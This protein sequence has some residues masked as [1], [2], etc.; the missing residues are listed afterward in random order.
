LPSE[1]PLFVDLD[2]TV[3]KSDML[4]ESFLWLLKHRPWILLFTP[5]WLLRGRATLKYEIASRARPNIENL[6]LNPEFMEF[7]TQQ[8]GSGREIILISASDERVTRSVADHLGLFTQ[9]FGS[10]AANNLKAEKKLWRIQSLCADTPYAYAGDS[11]ADL[12]VWQNAAQIISVNASSDVRR[13]INALQRL[14]Q[15]ESREEDLHFDEPQPSFAL[16]RSMR[17]HQWLKNALLFLPLLLSHRV[18]ETDLLFAAFIGF[19]AFSLC[20]S[21]VYLL[22]DMLDLESDRLHATKKTRPFAAGE[23]SLRSGFLLAPA[24]LVAA[25]CCA[26]LLNEE[27]LLTL[28]GYWLA[29]L[30]YSLRIKSL[31]FIDALTLAG[32]FCVR[33]LAGAAAIEVTATTWLLS[34]ALLVFFG[35]ALVKRHAELMNLR[36]QGKQETAG[37]AYRVSHLPLLLTLGPSANVA[38]IAVFAF[39]ALGDSA[40]ELYNQ[41]LLLL[42]ACPGMFYLVA[43]VWRLARAGELEEDPVRFAIKDKISQLVIALCVGVFW[44]AI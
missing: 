36:K 14:S 15:P 8:S 19:A 42:A 1:A 22:N 13:K 26:A 2:G 25:F 38:A 7:L 41:P 39:Y 9:T 11:P 17:P 34:F 5:L 40:A 10:D 33:I 32:L 28:A 29:T 4:F 44:L 24:L 43:R 37:R 21:S 27:F 20:A 3:I 6:P 30:C 23:L 18:Q 35:L 12:V 31:L 16:L